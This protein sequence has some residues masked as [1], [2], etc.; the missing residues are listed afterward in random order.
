MTGRAVIFIGAFLIGAFP[1]CG[2]V[3]GPRALGT[4]A[5]A[6]DIVGVGAGVET[7]AR[8]GEGEAAA[9]TGVEARA[10]TA[11]NSLL[12]TVECE[13]PGRYNLEGNTGALLPLM[14]KLKLIRMG[15]P[16][17]VNIVHIGDSHIQA[18]FFTGRVR[19][20][21]NRDFSSAGRGLIVPL[22][23]T[24]TNEPVDYAVTSPNKWIWS[25]CSEWAP[26][27]PAGL[28]GVAIATAE[29]EISFEISSDEP[30]NQVTVFHHP[31]APAL[32][33]DAALLSG[34]ECDP[35][36]AE[37]ITYV[38][39]AEETSRVRLNGRI[40]DPSYAMPVFYGFL[41]E[42]GRG[43]I[44]Y[45]SI[46]VNG[47]TYTHYNRSPQIVPLLS[48]LEPDLVIISLGTNDSYGT[49]FNKENLSRQ[50]ET[51]LLSI[52][53]NSPDAVILLTTPMEC[54]VSTRNRTIN[55]NVE[56][57]REAII[58]A[59]DRFSLPYW[60]MY[61]AVGGAGAMNI[62]LAGG[63]ANKD[64]IHLTKEGYWKQGDMLHS[65]IINL[66][67]SN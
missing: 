27:M 19:D 60:D 42:N 57:V 32:G 7:K 51:L 29:R 18:G 58:S 9:G 43:G 26:S 62:W 45:N 22:K 30:F 67:N 5:E 24:G 16:E 64:K 36:G 50:I 53:E 54:A 23:I 61:R 52:M 20:N 28:G 35:Y 41:L 15:Y 37:N 38:S 59:A 21:L 56:K 6:G 31:E 25:R 39:L 40:T 11:T 17:R 47:C 12:T 8:V 10:I 14:N 63:L 4:E 13:F 55:K 65:A 48:H 49:G 66:Y 1:Y 46:G 3:A 2:T 33:A 34:I 44:L